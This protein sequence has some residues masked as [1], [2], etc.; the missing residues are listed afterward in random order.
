MYQIENLGDDE[1]DQ[2]EF[3]SNTVPDDVDE[4]VVHYKPRELRNLSPVDEL[5]SLSPLVDAKVANLNNEET[6]QIYALCG[7]GS[8]SSFRM[9]KHGLEVSEMAVSELPGH[10]NAVWT[11][12]S[13]AKGESA[14][15]STILDTFR[16]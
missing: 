1:E 4:L 11:V 2:P 14:S 6:P 5:E 15:L 16:G 13:S 3:E 7:R 9:M 8:R 10:P 12:K